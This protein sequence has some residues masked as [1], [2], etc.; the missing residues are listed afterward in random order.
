MRELA[1][2]YSPP[3]M[4][5]MRAESPL[6]HHYVPRLGTLSRLL[7]STCYVPVIGL[8]TPSQ[9]AGWSVPTSFWLRVH[10]RKEMA[11]RKMHPLTQRI[12]GNRGH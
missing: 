9:G 10:C 11:A 12:S 4:I 7:L 8:G 1:L 2:G 6:T 5:P 3:T